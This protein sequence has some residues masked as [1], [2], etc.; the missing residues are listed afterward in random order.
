LGL[1]SVVESPIIPLRHAPGMSLNSTLEPPE[2][3]AIF[4]DGDALTVINRAGEDSAGLGYLEQL[5]SAL[6]YYLGRH[7]GRPRQILVLGAGG[8]TQV[9]QAVHYTRAQ[10]DTEIHAVE[11]NPQVVNLVRTRYLEFAGGLY[12][13][14]KVRLHLGDARGFVATTE[15]HFD[16]IQLAA[17]GASGAASAGLFA[18]SESY[19]YTV[20]ALQAYLHR[21][22]PAG[23]L[24]ISQRINLPPRETLKLFA[25][26]VAALRASGVSDPSSRLAL[27]RGWQTSTLVVKKSPFTPR[28]LEALQ[29]FAV[30]RSFD[31]AWYPGMQ[32]AE[33]NR[34]NLLRQPYF[35]LAARSLLSAN[36]DDFLDRY[37]F[38]IHPATDD[39]PYFSH[40]FRWP[41][42]PELLALRGSGGMPLVEWGYLIIV[43][44]L[45]QATLA[46]LV[47]IL[48]PLWLARS[49]PEARRVDY[50]RGR[51]FLYF[52]FLGLGFLFLEIA[53]IQ[54][55]LLFLHHP[56]Y[57][58]AIVLTAFLLF[59]GLGSGWSQRQ[60]E[61]RS[62]KAAVATAALG[63]VLLGAAYA[64]GLSYVFN[65]F[66]SW[67]T[68]ARAAL[69][70]ALIAPLAFCM[71]IPFP[72]GLSRLAATEPGL[73]PWA[74]GVNGC[75]SVLSAVLASLLAVDFG[76]TKLLLLALT[77]YASA[78]LVFQRPWSRTEKGAKA[79][80]L[81]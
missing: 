61:T 73:L 35:H 47:L 55:F 30:A 18:L 16:L 4:T 12:D 9:L 42:L 34:F 66:V 71:G 5:G 25:T 46:S 3:V 57:A 21:L 54:K 81:S 59:A 11:L 70:I 56:L 68:L 37:K 23:Y 43:A 6:P 20:E 58:T 65:A 74:W 1:I 15:Q 2:Q 62:H 36:P 69:T 49:G 45:V 26:A 52:L 13:Q 64:F 22:T 53:F 39:R 14:A 63:I 44:T 8:G 7:L 75:A 19:L 28:E 29:T 80:K 33:A 72:M 10:T 27:I 78:A 76:I 32:A 48:L 38:D 51:I 24:T 41:V 77:L 17:L 31:R 67:P 50:G 40:F 79:Q 60:A